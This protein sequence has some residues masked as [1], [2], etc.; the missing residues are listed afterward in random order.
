MEAQLPVAL[1]R[2]PLSAGRTANLFNLGEP[3]LRRIDTGASAG[4]A[5]TRMRSGPAR[6][7]D[8][9][10]DDDDDGDDDNDDYDD[11]F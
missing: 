2:R 8:D 5:S 10:D 9:D 4:D 1:T 11:D 6:H 7:D 3:L